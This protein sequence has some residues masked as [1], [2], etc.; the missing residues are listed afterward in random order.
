MKKKAKKKKSKKGSKSANDA[1][2]SKRIESLRGQPSNAPS[3]QEACQQRLNA[4]TITVPPR[5]P[6]P[7]LGLSNVLNS[8]SGG[9]PAWNTIPTGSVSP[10]QYLNLFCSSPRVSPSSSPRYTQAAALQNLLN[11]L[12]PPSS[13]R[14][15]YRR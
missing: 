14:G 1:N 10:R 6:S 12:T 13:P 2:D 15:Q 7:V 11:F 3:F 4:L 5:T 9:L 8:V